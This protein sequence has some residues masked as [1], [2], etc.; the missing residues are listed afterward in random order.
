LIRAIALTRRALLAA[1]LSEVR[2]RRAVRRPLVATAA[3]KGEIEFMQA[4]KD[5]VIGNGVR[6]EYV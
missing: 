5:E 6:Q 4:I 2:K 1:L 3:T